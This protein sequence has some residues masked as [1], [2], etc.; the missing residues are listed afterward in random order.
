MLTYI[1][2]HRWHCLA[3]SDVR[4]VWVCLC[5]DRLELEANSLPQSGHFCLADLVFGVDASKHLIFSSGIIRSE[6]SDMAG[7]DGEYVDEHS[8]EEGDKAGEDDLEEKLK[9][10]G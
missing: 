5:R 10:K 6:L 2:S 4:A 3:V 9:S 8:D 1:L 7:E